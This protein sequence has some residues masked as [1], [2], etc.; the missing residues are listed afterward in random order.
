[1]AI[2]RKE[3]LC[4]DLEAELLVSECDEWSEGD[5]SEDSNCVD[6][7][8]D[9]EQQ[10]IQVLRKKA[11]PEIVAD[12]SSD[13]SDE[14]YLNTV[15]NIN[16]EWYNDYPHIGYDINGEK[17]TKEVAKDR[18]DEF[19]NSM[20]KDT[21]KSVYD[22]LEGKDILLSKEDLELLKKVQMRQFPDSIDPYEVFNSLILAYN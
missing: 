11:A 2:K 7:Y 4:K 14:E 17:I 1:M 12:Y 15:G 22:K 9:F 8:D 3:E 16:M 10:R 21:W 6:E 20:N 5:A 18:L 19:L 13:S